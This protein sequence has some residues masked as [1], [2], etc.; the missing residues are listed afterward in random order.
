MVMNAWA[1]D[2]MGG[3]MP[4][5]WRWF[6]CILCVEE[7][8]QGVRLLYAYMLADYTRF[9]FFISKKDSST[10][11]VGGSHVAPGVL[12]AWAREYAEGL[13]MAL[14]IHDI[15]T[16]GLDDA[17]CQMLHAS[18]V[19]SHFLSLLA[20]P[21]IDGPRRATRVWHVYPY[22]A[23]G[24]HA[25]RCLF[26]PFP[27]PPSAPFPGCERCLPALSA[28]AIHQHGGR[29]SWRKAR[30]ASTSVAAHNS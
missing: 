5:V 16:F 22:K 3:V 9:A 23:C 18:C 17:E 28:C 4:W 29:A 21:A 24:V 30:T 1:W 27:P 6:G 10:H 26:E 14:F 25:I 7:E 13:V 19:F 8:H 11:L 2:L 20:L 12:D 15:Y